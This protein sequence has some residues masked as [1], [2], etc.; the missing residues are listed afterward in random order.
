M[1]HTNRLSTRGRAP[2][3]RV[4]WTDGPNSNSAI[5]ST[6]VDNAVVW[7]TG[8]AALA[9]NTLIRIRG[10][11]SAWLSLITSVGDGF[12]KYAAGIGIVSA[13]A[14][15][16]GALPTP[17]GD[18]DWSGWMWYH[19][20]GAMVGDVTTEVFRSPMA[21]IR[22]E[23][24]TKAMRKVGPNETIFGVFQVVGEVGGSTV[25]FAVSTRMLFKL[26]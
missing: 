9:Q 26:H 3:R 19:A 4:E 2:R 7:T 1:A 17:S 11:L 14:F 18:P 23:I 10:E 20:G 21:A 6:S 8:Q 16:A 5:Q 24:D 15:A 12:A 25:N 22:L 13:D